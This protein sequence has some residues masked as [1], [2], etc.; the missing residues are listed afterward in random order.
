MTT[1]VIIDAFEQYQ[2]WLAKLPH[3]SPEP[4]RVVETTLSGNKIPVWD[5]ELVNPAINSEEKLIH[6]TTIPYY[7]LNDRHIK[8]HDTKGNLVVD[9]CGKF[10]VKCNKEGVIELPLYDDSGISVSLPQSEE[11]EASGR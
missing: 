8:I 2:A 4:S 11:V 9:E 3:L 7:Q 5:L 10:A 6:A 1:E